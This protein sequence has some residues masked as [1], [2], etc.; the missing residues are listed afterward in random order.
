[1]FRLVSNLYHKDSVVRIK[2]ARH[3]SKDNN[4]EEVLATD[5]P[6]KKDDTYDL[7]QSDDG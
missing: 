5:A 6:D 2:R 1:M 7:N 3:D 4:G